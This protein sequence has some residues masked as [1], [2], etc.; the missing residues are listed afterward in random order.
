MFKAKAF[1]PSGVEHLLVRCPSC[2]THLPCRCKHIDDLSAEFLNE[3][4][5]DEGN[6][7]ERIREQILGN[8]GKYMRRK[9]RVFDDPKQYL[10][11]A[12]V[13][14]KKDGTSSST[15]RRT[16]MPPVACTTTLSVEKNLESTLADDAPITTIAINEIIDTFVSSIVTAKVLCVAASAL[17]R[18]V[19][20]RMNTT[21]FAP[22]KLEEEQLQLLGEITDSPAEAYVKTV[23]L[24]ETIAVDN[25]YGF[26]R[27]IEAA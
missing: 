26:M 12:A 24:A 14:S 2:S 8:L 4:I 6:I 5:R 20:Q 13:Q 7:S 22:R 10:E 17:A 11:S 25:F 21:M 15:F 9:Y 27:R 23:E 18:V 1:D 19:Q 16:Q 3:R